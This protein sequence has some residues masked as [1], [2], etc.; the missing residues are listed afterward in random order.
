MLIGISSA[1]GQ[2]KSTVISSLSE[3]GYRVIQSQTS[4]AILEEWNTSLAEIDTKPELRMEFQDEIFNRHHDLIKPFA[5]SSEVYF[6]ERT[7]SDI[8]TYTVISL[9]LYN[10]FSDWIETY[11]S[12]CKNA[13]GLFSGICVLSGLDQIESDGVRSINRHFAEL[14]SDRIKHYTIDMQFNGDKNV[15]LLNEPDHNKRLER[16]LHFV[17][18]NYGRI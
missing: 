17:S 5:E 10:E 9:G 7:F 16:I 6:V 8:F 1:Q 18:N 14:V 4:R 2:G 15:L 13:Q 11:Y 3:A 12:R